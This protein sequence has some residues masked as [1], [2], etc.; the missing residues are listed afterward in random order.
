KQRLEA[1]QKERQKLPTSAQYDRDPELRQQETDLAETIARLEQQWREA[2]KNARSV[3]T[4]DEIAHI[5]Q[6]WTG[7]PVMRIVEAETTKLLR[8]ADKLH[9]RVIGQD[10]AV[11]AVARAIRRARSGLKDP[12]RPMGSFLFLGPT[13]T[14]KTFLAKTLAEFLFE[15]ENA[16]IRIDM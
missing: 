14:G 9:E 5:V 1:I 10:D 12:K 11:Q 6:T 2:G 8:M 13:G 4:E 7:I 3:V 16:M 15:D